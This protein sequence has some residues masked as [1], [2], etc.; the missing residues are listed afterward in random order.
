[1]ATEFEHR[2]NDK[3]ALAK[4]HLDEFTNRKERSSGDQFERGHQESFLFHLVGAR[5][6]FL[7]EINDTCGLGLPL[8]RVEMRSVREGLAKRGLA[9]NAFDRIDSLEKD[10]KSWLFQILDLRNHC[11]HRL[12]ISRQFHRGGARNGQIFL[13]LPR[14][15]VLIEK[16]VHEFFQE[17]LE[18]MER[19]IAELRPT[20][21]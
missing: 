2:T 21:P 13:V 14:T 10:G 18:E 15:G 9:S 5:D 1:M 6:S 8:E 20:L 11:S 7:Q 4:I 16:D 12:H 17:C 3:L 19:L